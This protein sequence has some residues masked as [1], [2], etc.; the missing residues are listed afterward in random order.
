MKFI[1]AMIPVVA[2]ALVVTGWSTAE[3]SQHGIERMRASLA[4]ESMEAGQ[5]TITNASYL[6]NTRSPSGV[7]D[8]APP[9]QI[10]ETYDADPDGDGLSN[11]DE[12]ANF[13]DPNNSDTDGDGLTDLEEVESGS[14][15]T[16]AT[17]SNLGNVSSAAVTSQD[18]DG[19]GLPD[20]WENQYGLTSSAASGV[21]D[22]QGDPDG[23]HMV[24]IDEWANGTDPNVVD[25]DD[26]GLLDQWEVENGLNPLNAS[27]EN[28]SGGD[29]DGDGLTNEQEQLYH[30][31]PVDADTDA[32]TLPDEWELA[33]GLSPLDSTG[34]NGGQ[35]DPDK[36]GY[37]NSAEYQNFTNPVKADVPIDDDDD[38]V[39]PTQR[40]FLPQVEN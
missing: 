7:S 14:D 37:V 26:D 15:P 1:R 34:G 13:T 4:Q 22:P 20:E 33:F 17:N 32:D 38:N 39:A 19:N 21:P 23:D 6:V 36:D 25:T 24:N 31:N 10:D 40:L 9:A 29:Y 27:D 5:G 35:G 16:D 12:Y 30:T 3:N 11:A 2:L 18:Q 8:A 28:G